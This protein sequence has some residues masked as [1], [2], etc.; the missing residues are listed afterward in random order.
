LTGEYGLT[1]TSLY[2]IVNVGASPGFS[3]KQ[4]LFLQRAYRIS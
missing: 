4:A 2:Y 1:S 3:A